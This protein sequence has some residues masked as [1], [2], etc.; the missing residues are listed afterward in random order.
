MQVAPLKVLNLNNIVNDVQ[1]GLILAE[2][3]SLIQG[4]QRTNVVHWHRLEQMCDDWMVLAE[5][6]RNAGPD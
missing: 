4:E 2:D 1:K 3:S 5:S 6:T